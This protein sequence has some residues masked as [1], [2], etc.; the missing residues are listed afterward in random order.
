MEKL[1]LSLLLV[2]LGLAT[3]ADARSVISL[4]G[5]VETELYSEEAY[6]GEQQV[7]IRLATVEVAIDAKINESVNSHLLWLYEEGNSSDEFPVM[8]EGTISLRMGS[9][10]SLTVGKQYVPFGVFS[11]SLVSDPLTLQ[12]GETNEVALLYDFASGIFNSALYVFNGTSA[13]NSTLAQGNDTD[14]GY[15]V[16]LALE[17]EDSYSLRLGYLSNIADTDALQSLSGSN[18][19][20]FVAGFAIS[21]NV[22]L[23]P[24]T[25]TAEHI[26][27]LDPFVNGDLGGDVPA[28]S[29]PAASLMD[30]S[31]QISEHHALGVSYQSTS[32][33]LFL[34][35]PASAY[36]ISLSLGVA[37]STKLSFEFVQ[38]N[39]YSVSDGG[40][41]QSASQ[42]LIQLATEF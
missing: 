15:G 19:A 8:D 27:A 16:S 41:D 33:A 13:T 18:V 39:D 38:A 22:H 23:G 29:T 1:Q 9:H 26:S 3:S 28:D 32:D 25:I 10:S 34:G 2:S 37:D 6:S 5:G 11:T 20:D 42:F 30:L 7:G 31:Y 21:A 12:L 17:A 24:V 40:T 36:G 14:L 35:L 4:T